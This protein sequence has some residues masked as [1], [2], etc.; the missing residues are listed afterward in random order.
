[1]L[2]HGYTRSVLLILVALVLAVIGVIRLAATLEPRQRVVLILVFIL[3]L[4]YLAL[5]LSQL[6]LVGHRTD[7]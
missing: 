6:G 3:G 2:E 4:I 1:M 5:K 7:G